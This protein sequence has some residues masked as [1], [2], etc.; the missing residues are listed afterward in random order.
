MN[1]LPLRVGITP[2]HRCSYLPDQYEQLIVLVD[3]NYCTVSGYE[4]LLQ[5]G[6]RRSGNDIYRP[7]CTQ[8][9]A[10][11]SLRIDAAEFEPSRSHRRVQN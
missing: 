8:C 6:F 11:H 4:S 10:C 1:L 9:S 5:A 7:H 2:T 3:E